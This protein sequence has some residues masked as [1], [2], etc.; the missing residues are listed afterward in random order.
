MKTRFVLIV[1]LT[2]FGIFTLSSSVSAQ[3]PPPTETA[4]TK[5]W[6][7]EWSLSLPAGTTPEDV[8]KSINEKWATEKNWTN[9]STDG[10]SNSTISIWKFTDRTGQSWIATAKADPCQTHRG[11]TLVTLKIVRA[12]KPVSPCRAGGNSQMGSVRLAAKPRERAF[13]Y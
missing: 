7:E 11:N 4:D 13:Y 3:A 10:L 1:L 8:L 2:T 12:P 5:P 6:E 9:L